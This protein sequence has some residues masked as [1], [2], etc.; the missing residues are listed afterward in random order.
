MSGAMNLKLFITKTGR[1]AGRIFSP[2]FWRRRMVLR[3]RRNAVNVR[4]PQN[5]LLSGEVLR[6]M[7]KQGDEEKQEHERKADQI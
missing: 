2:S 7:L 4:V 1:L 5:G 6:E 3:A